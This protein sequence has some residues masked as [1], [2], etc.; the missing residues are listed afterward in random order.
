MGPGLTPKYTAANEY[1]NSRQM[2]QEIH[3]PGMSSWQASYIGPGARWPS[4]RSYSDRERAQLQQ[5]LEFDGLSVAQ[6]WRTGMMSD[7]ELRRE[8][9]RYY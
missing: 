9:D 8:F 3:Y 4:A 1:G 6:G 7:A 5:Q 2:R